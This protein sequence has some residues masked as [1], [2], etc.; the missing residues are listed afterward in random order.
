[1][2]TQAQHS[3]PGQSISAA[4]GELAQS[5]AAIP[6]PDSLYNPG[7]EDTAWVEVINRMD[8]VYTDL[9]ES[10]ITLEQQH[11]ALE[12]AQYFID[13]VLKSMSD[14]LIVCDIN[15]HIQQVNNAL[16][17]LVGLSADDL[18]NTPLKSLFHEPYKS[19]VDSFAVHIRSGSLIDCEVE[20]IDK[21]NKPN[22]MAMNC[23]PRY[24]AKQRLSGF[25]VTG[26]PLGELRRAYAELNKAHESLKNTQH[27]LIQ[28]EKMASLGRL[29]AGVAHELNNP[30]SFVFGNMHA[31]SR[32]GERFRQYLEAIHTGISDKE[33][34]S[35]REALKIDRSLNDIGPLI[36][37]TQEGAERVSEIVQ[38]LSRFTNAKE[39]SQESFDLVRLT[40]TAL[41][42]VKKACS[43][44][45][46]IAMDMP[47]SLYITNSEGH[48]HQI[49][50]NLIQNAYDA[51]EALPDA[52]LTISIDR[53]GDI[54]NVRIK[55]NGPG[56]PETDLLRVFDPFFTSKPVGKGTGLGLYI[57]YGLATEQCNGALEIGNNLGTGAYATLSLPYI[58]TEH[59]Q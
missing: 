13:S 21:G 28:S 25:V 31:L 59:E 24:D 34:E 4:I 53:Q 8:E 47:E 27:H 20:L 14:V 18:L 33:R 26:R 9:V 51:V 49:L 30:I 56:I 29:I 1:M 32:Y 52:R 45:P 6:A 48:I 22:P 36:E 41:H 54:V 10:Q 50:I 55:D 16:E 43:R 39:R 17:E 5:V 46:D 15:G 7:M 23:T 38:N 11:A 35:L 2:T 57:S 3:N 44:K 40:Q 42:W 37:G 12:E 58:D 19:R